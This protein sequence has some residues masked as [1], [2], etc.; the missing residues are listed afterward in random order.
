VAEVIPV[1]EPA[2]QTTSQVQ[3][4]F[5]ELVEELLAQDDTLT[6]NAAVQQAVKTLIEAQPNNVNRILEVAFNTYPDFAQ[7]IINVASLTNEISSDDAL[8]LALASNVDP[9]TVTSS[10][11]AGGTGGA[12]GAGG[13]NPQVANVFTPPVGT[14]AGSGGGG[15]GDT[16]VSTN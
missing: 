16:T 15:G 12:T 14:G 1:V 8:D 11:A 4:A 13:N 7:D 2:T 5:D 9:T 6:R 3:V 10:T